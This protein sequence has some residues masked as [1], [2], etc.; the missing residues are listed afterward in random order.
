MKLKQII[1]NHS[2]RNDPHATVTAERLLEYYGRAVSTLINVLDP[3]LIVIGVGVGNVELLY[4]EG[5]ERVKKYVFNP[6]QLKTEIRKPE[7]GDSA[8]VYGAALLFAN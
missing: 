4:T 6:G 1:E 3:N 7:L 2:G 5:Y 8:G